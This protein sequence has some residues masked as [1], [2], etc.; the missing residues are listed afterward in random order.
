MAAHEGE[1]VEVGRAR[2][3]RRTRG[4]GPRTSRGRGRS[5]GRRSRDRG[6]RALGAARGWRAGRHDRGR[7]PCCRQPAR[8]ER[9]VRCR[10]AAVPP[11]R[12]SGPAPGISQRP[13]SNGSVGSGAGTSA[14]PARSNGSGAGEADRTVVARRPPCSVCRSWCGFG[15]R[16]PRRWRWF[17]AVGAAQGCELG[18]PCGGESA[19][20]GRRP[21][22]GGSTSRSAVSSVVVGRSCVGVERAL[23]ARSRRAWRS[24]WRVKSPRSTVASTSGWAPARSGS[25]VMPR[26]NVSTSPTARRWAGSSSAPSDSR[27]PR[28]N[29]DA[30]GGLDAVGEDGAV[31]GGQVSGQ[32]IPA[33]QRLG[34]EHLARPRLRI[35]LV[36]RHR[37]VSGSTASRRPAATVVR[38]LASWSQVST[39]ADA[40]RCGSQRSN[41]A[42]SRS[43]R[44]AASIAALAS[45]ISPARERRAR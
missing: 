44:A 1:V 9:C 45:P 19:F 32:H 34:Q 14:R 24:A 40:T 6:R 43:V 13:R 2:H 35:I 27:A 33:A 3:P 23:D 17:A 5:R 30:V 22:V 37:L 7:G 36:G 31:L 4:G 11:R 20:L 18:D 28:W 8:C 16:S 29:S 10:R 15:R 41:S 42:A 26:L 21:G 25:A 12:G 38:T 39:F